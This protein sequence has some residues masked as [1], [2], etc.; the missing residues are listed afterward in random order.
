MIEFIE[1]TSCYQNQL[2]NPR[3]S[4][5][6]YFIKALVKEKCLNERHANLQLNHL[7][8]ED[9]SYYLTKAMDNL[10]QYRDRYELQVL[11]EFFHVNL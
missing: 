5:L 2:A 4:G 6:V 1:K 10:S 9:L 7:V 8:K 3:D 11:K